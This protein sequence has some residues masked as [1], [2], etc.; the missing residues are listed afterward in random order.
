MGA[1]S[2][3]R[4]VN[5]E[6]LARRCCDTAMTSRAWVD[7]N[8]NLLCVELSNTGG[9]PLALSVQNFMGANSSAVPASVP[10]SAS[11]VKI[12]CEQYGSGR[13]FFTGEMADVTVLDRALSLEEIAAL[14]KAERKE[15]QPFDGKAGKPF[16]APEISKALTVSG[17]IKTTTLSTEADYIV[18]KGEWS[19]AYSLGLSTGHL[20]FTIGG[21]ML[22]CDD[23][24]PLNQ[25][26]HVAGVYDGKQVVGIVDG[27]VKNP[28]LPPPQP[29]LNSSTSQMP[30]MPRAA[31][32]DSPPGSSESTP[33]N[34]IS[35]PANPLS[36]PRPYGSLNYTT[37]GFG[38]HDNGGKLLH[39]VSTNGSIIVG[40]LISSAAGFDQWGV[41]KEPSEY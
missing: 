26:F 33:P 9:K 15:T 36:S 18:S 4:I 24:L 11:P 29:M 30:R 5:V 27:K 10:V 34:S 40:A 13:W 21:F 6:L 14:A 32:L 2:A 28:A 31:K 1:L 20:R 12:G 17:W 16:T 7:A 35:P 23:P 37:A 39:T 41:A 3:R 19:Q 8:Q 25:W 22:Q 38:F